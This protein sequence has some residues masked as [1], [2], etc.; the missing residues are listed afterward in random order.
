MGIL[1]IT[2][3][4]FFDG[5]KYQKKEALLK[6]VDEMLLQGSDWI[7]IGAESTRPGSKPLDINEEIERL[8]NF[9]SAFTNLPKGKFSIDTSRGPIAHEALKFG[10]TMVN[11]VY[12][13]QRDP[14]LADIIRDNGC[15]I[16]L[17]HMQG[18]P[19]TMQKA[20]HYDNILDSV[21]DFLE[22]RV[23]YAL[24]R[25]IQEKQIILDPG[26]GF[27]KNLN[28]NL[29]LLK[30]I[31]TLKRLGFPL[32]I[33]PSHKRFIGDILG[34]PVEDRLYGTLGVLAHL[35]QNEVD[36]VRLHDVKASCQVRDIVSLLHEEKQ[37]C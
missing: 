19:E 11:D 37:K 35:V 18:T 10:F 1:N 36:F 9:L 33:G 22:K 7:D 21:C 28:H 20:P 15:S 24:S 4:S 26:I 34:C 5:G 6:R 27:G 29:E 25:G 17:M 12:A 13:L 8:Q 14:E 16:V 23:Q 32:L 2:P 3:D 31:P 30:N